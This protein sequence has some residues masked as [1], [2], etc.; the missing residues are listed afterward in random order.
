M[1]NQPQDK[2]KPHV[3]TTQPKYPPTA[4]TP[5]PK[6]VWVSQCKV[7]PYC[8]LMSTS[9]ITVPKENLTQPICPGHFLQ[10]P[11]LSICKGSVDWSVAEW[12]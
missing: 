9:Q 8:S 12:T 6:M 3:D 5:Q 2:L 11:R 1:Q 7:G 4:S 10:E